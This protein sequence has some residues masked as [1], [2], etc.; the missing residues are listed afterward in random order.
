MVAH[1]GDPRLV[2]RNLL[3][4]RDANGVPVIQGFM[5]L[6]KRGDG[7]LCYTWPNPAGEGEA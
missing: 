5:K 7:W 2:G 3:D 6:A 4:V 1:D